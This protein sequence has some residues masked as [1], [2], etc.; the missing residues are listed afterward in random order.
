MSIVTVVYVPEGIGMAADSRL[1]GYRHFDKCV[2][3]RFAIP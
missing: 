1:T 2:T 3:V